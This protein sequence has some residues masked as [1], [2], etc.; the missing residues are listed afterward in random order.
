[1]PKGVYQKSEEH[2]NL[3]RQR[4][5]Q[6]NKHKSESAR[7]RAS[8]DA[9]IQV[10]CPHCGRVGQKIAMQRWHFSNCKLAPIEVLSGDTSSIPV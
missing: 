4:L 10:E 5:I 6:L 7:A 1:M 8:K 3:S 2:I 9:L